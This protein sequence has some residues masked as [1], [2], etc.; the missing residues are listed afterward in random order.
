MKRLIFSVA[1][2]CQ[3][4]YRLQSKHHWRTAATCDPELG[5]DSLSE[6]GI[7]RYRIPLD[8][9]GWELQWDPKYLNDD[10]D[11]IITLTKKLH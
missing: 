4:H 6:N 9:M 3:Y 2:V 5:S 8:F 1:V 7:W 10:T 11:W